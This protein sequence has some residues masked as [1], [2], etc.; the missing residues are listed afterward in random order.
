MKYTIVKTATLNADKMLIDSQEKTII[1]QA[2]TINTLNSR[3][4]ELEEKNTKQ[5]K[6]IAERGKT[7]IELES[8]Q[9]EYETICN[10]QQARIWELE[11]NQRDNHGRLLRNLKK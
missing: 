2:N 5:G 11:Q 3:N 9:A 1:R 6:T 10:K 8:K 4:N 7:I